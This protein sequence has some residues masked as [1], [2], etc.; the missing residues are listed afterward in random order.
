[1]SDTVIYTCGKFVGWSGLI[2]FT[3][4][5]LERHTSLGKI[6]IRPRTQRYR[7]NHSA[8]VWEKEREWKKFEEKHVYEYNGS[9]KV[10]F[11]QR[12]HARGNSKVRSPKTMEAFESPNSTAALLKRYSLSLALYASVKRSTLG[13]MYGS[14]SSFWDRSSKIFF[15]QTSGCSHVKKRTDRFFILWMV[16]V[17]SRI[18]SEHS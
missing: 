14:I 2:K 8:R 10:Y 17:I 12:T 15:R 11:T 6:S 9:R 16:L 5:W 7:E 13:Y 18:K 3:L 4:F 1:M